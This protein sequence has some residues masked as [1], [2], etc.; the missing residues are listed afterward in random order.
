M[1]HKIALLTAAA[2]LLTGCSSTATAS[3][4]PEATEDSPECVMV[5]EGTANALRNGITDSA[6]TLGDIAAAEAPNSDAWFVAAEYTSPDTDGVAVWYT[7]HDPAG[8]DNAFVSIDA[9]AEVIS[10]Y[11][12]PT[13]A[14]AAMEGAGLAEACLK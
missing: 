9:V 4:E 10:M 2:L 3:P 13:D 7:T 5:S 1:R 6:V 11:Q 12:R 8:D 14:S